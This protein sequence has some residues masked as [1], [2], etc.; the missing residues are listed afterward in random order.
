ML[1]HLIVDDPTHFSPAVQAHDPK[2]LLPLA[3]ADPSD[4]VDAQAATSAFLEG[5]DDVEPNAAVDDAQRKAAREAF[6]AMTAG[7]DVLDIRTKLTQIKVPQAVQHLVGM[8]SAYDWEFMEQAKELRG[9]AVSQILEETKN[10]DAR[11]RLRALELLGRVTEVALFTPPDLVATGNTN[12]GDGLRLL[13]HLFDRELVRTTA[14]AKGD[15]RPL[16]FILSDGAPTD[17]EWPRHA[18]LLALVLQG[19][20]VAG[21]DLDGAHALGQQ[22]RKAGAG[23][24]DAGGRACDVGRAAGLGDHQVGQ[25][26]AHAAHQ[27]VHHLLEPRVVHGLQAGAHAPETVG[28]R[29][30]QLGDEVGVLDLAA[31]GRPVLAVQ[32]DVEHRPEF[33]LQLQALAH[34][35]L[36]PGVVVAHGQGCGCRFAGVEQSVPRVKRVWF[37]GWH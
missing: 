14:D 30:H 12:L 34:A 29:G 17:T 20:A 16:V 6:T 1:E 25:S 28:R 35:H 5:F 24:V 32:R 15:W 9:Y 10:P 27:Q 23:G 18:Q 37:R 36:H 26:A 19:E 2:S 4:I 33:G 3:K 22:R 8:L 7:T 13:L 21:L 31:H 11:L